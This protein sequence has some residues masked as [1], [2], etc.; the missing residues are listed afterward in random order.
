MNTHTLNVGIVW[1]GPLSLHMFCAMGVKK[2]ILVVEI[3]V[4]LKNMY[5]MPMFCPR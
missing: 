4:I 2:T 1:N 5:S 3:S